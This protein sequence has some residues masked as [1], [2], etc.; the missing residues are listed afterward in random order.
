MD[1]KLQ[2]KNVKM[3]TCIDANNGYQWILS[4]DG[5]MGLVYLPTLIPYKSTI[6]VGKYP[7]PMDPMGMEKK[8]V[9][10]FVESQ[11]DLLESSW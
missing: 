6:H 9:V 11:F 10:K 2:K 5:S 3:A 4:H 8:L 7:N 1:G